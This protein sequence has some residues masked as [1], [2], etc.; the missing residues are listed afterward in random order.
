ME[1]NSLLVSVIIP[2]YNASKTIVRALESV[3]NQKIRYPYEVLIINDGSTDDSTKYVKDY[4]VNNGLKNFILIDQDNSGVSKARN[5]GI[6]SA[7]GKYIAFLD[8]DDYWVE[9][10]IE[11]QMF[12]LEKGFDFVCGLR[13]NEKISFPYKLENEYAVISLNKLLIKVVGQTSTAIFNRKV[14][15]NSGFFDEEQRYSEDANLWMKISKSNKMIILNEVLVR[16][17]NDYGNTG[18]SSN[19]VAMENGVRK[20][21]K[22]MY[23]LN[24]INFV[25]YLFFNFFS[26][27]KYLKRRYL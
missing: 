7:K 5:R 14:I 2:M 24:R 15:D 9:N 12:F 23:E 20:N 25:Q 16:T 11:K 4:I 26:Y 10:K 17:D 21:I 13:N 19:L 3:R 18:L 6:I 1:E 22:E 8:A 27:I